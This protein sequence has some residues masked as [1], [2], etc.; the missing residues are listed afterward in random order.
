M[1]LVLCVEAPHVECQL[2]QDRDLPRP[3]HGCILVS[4]VPVPGTV[5]GT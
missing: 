2:P 5:P 1:V 3:L 4:S